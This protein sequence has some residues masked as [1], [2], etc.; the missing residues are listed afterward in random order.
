MHLKLRS[1]S[2][3]Y[4]V[5]DS[6]SLI[7]AWF[8]LFYIFFHWTAFQPFRQ[9]NFWNTKYFFDIHFIFFFFFSSGI[10]KRWKLLS[11]H[12]RKKLQRHLSPFCIEIKILKKIFSILKCLQV[13][14]KLTIACVRQHFCSKKKKNLFVKINLERLEEKKKNNNLKIS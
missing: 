6:K 2:L 11:N 12:C 9:F 10:F 4:E 5:S 1:L 7:K 13:K 3:L 8:N 14:K